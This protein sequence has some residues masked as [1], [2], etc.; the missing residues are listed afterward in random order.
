M[1]LSD[2][3][4]KKGI[5]IVLSPLGPD[6]MLPARANM[7]LDPRAQVFDGSRHPRVDVEESLYDGMNAGQIS[8]RPLNRAANR[9]YGSRELGG[10]YEARTW[11]RASGPCQGLSKRA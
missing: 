1:A 6:D 11:V 4:I 7:H 2:K 5:N 9:L 3:T 10:N 8:R